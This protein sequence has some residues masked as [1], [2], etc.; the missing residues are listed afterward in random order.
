MRCTCQACCLMLAAGLLMVSVSGCTDYDIAMSVEN[1]DQPATPETWRFELSQ[2]LIPATRATWVSHFSLL[3]A[4]DWPEPTAAAFKAGRQMSALQFGWFNRGV[5]WHSTAVGSR[6]FLFLSPIASSPSLVYWEEG[7]E[8]QQRTVLQDVKG[9]YQD[10]VLFDVATFEGK[11][12]VVYAKSDSLMQLVA[13]PT[14]A[15]LELA[16][17]ARRVADRDVEWRGSDANPYWRY[18]IGAIIGVIQEENVKDSGRLMEG[19]G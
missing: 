4:N 15:G 17:M 14:D 6:T 5:H 8:G 11:V 1:A 7:N 19:L 2:E 16:A 9:G 13:T 10:Q 3:S 18:L 12:I